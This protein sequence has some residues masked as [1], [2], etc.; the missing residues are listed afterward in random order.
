MSVNLTRYRE[1]T[2]PPPFSGR[3]VQGSGVRGNQAGR[4]KARSVRRRTDRSISQQDRRWD[5]G[6]RCI[7][8]APGCEL[9]PRPGQGGPAGMPFS[10]LATGR[11]WPGPQPTPH[12]RPTT[13]PPALGN[14]RLLRYG[15][16]VLV[17]APGR[18]GTLSTSAATE[19]RQPAACLSRPVRRG[20]RSQCTLSNL[21]KIAL[22]FSTFQNSTIPCASPGPT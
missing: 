3:L 22:T 2:Y 11:K 17:G 15:H 20:R 6:C 19:H 7:L 9:G 18:A 14:D 16:D 12:R 8:P 5:C 1:R 10:R 21:L 4:G 13:R